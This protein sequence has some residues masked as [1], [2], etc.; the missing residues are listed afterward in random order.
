M[1]LDKNSEITVTNRS[2][3]TLS[4]TIP[5]LNITRFFANGET[6]T[7]TMEELRKLSY[8]PGGYQLIE[9]YLV[10]FP[11]SAVEEI[12]GEVEPEYYY[13]VNAV[14]NLLE[15]GSLDELLDCLDFAPSGVI[16]L[17]KKISV[18]TRLNDVSKREAILKKTGFNIT[19]AIENSE[20]LENG[21]LATKKERRVRNIQ[22][23]QKGE[24]PVQAKLLKR[25]TAPKYNVITKQTVEEDV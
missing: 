12:L 14:T 13:D 9:Q 4:Y 22:E 3:G 23:V 20:I 19:K 1:L 24:P 6:K 11:V 21:E 17:I 16:E 15:K 25:R 7:I 10:I 8:I 5:D 2:N 18:D